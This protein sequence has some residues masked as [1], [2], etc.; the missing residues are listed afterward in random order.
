MFIKN[1]LKNTIYALV[2]MEKHLRVSMLE[3]RC[4]IALSAYFHNAP[5]M[6]GGAP[7]FCIG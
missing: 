7:N 4:E 3:K 2:C 1:T 5:N 6:S